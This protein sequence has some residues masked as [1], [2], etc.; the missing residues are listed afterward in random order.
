MT[1][2]TALTRREARYVGEV[3]FFADNPVSVDNTSH[4]TKNGETLHR[5]S[6]TRNLEALKFLWALVHKTADNT[7]R[8]R[9]KDTLMEHLKIRA[10]YYKLV[11]NGQDFEPVGKSLTRADNEKLRRLTDQF[12]DII[13][14]KILPGMQRNTLR[15][16]I[17]EMISGKS[18]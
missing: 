12:I 4:F 17:E 3:G 5:I 9:D 7:D 10:G 18:R 11:F 13:C 1:V 14:E 16:E 6:E 8:F 15:K 2:V